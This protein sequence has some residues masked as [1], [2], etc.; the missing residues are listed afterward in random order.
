MINEKIV[1]HEN[2]IL[3]KKKHKLLKK[4]IE[5]C[6][7]HNIS[8]THYTDFKS[9]IC[10][11]LRKSSTVLYGKKPIEMVETSQC[12]IRHE[13]IMNNPVFRIF[14]NFKSYIHFIG[15]EV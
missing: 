7:F 14:K 11:T 4:I 9:D 13:E 15:F 1:D 3:E 2:E 6:N 12:Y 8:V 10:L 5:Y